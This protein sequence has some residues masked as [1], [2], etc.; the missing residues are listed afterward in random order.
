MGKRLPPEI[1]HHIVYWADGSVRKKMLF[2]KAFN[3]SVLAFQYAEASLHILESDLSKLFDMGHFLRTSLSPIQV[4]HLVRA[5][6]YCHRFQ[7]EKQLHDKTGFLVPRS[8][9]SYNVEGRSIV[10][11]VYVSRDDSHD[12]FVTK[13]RIYRD[14]FVSV[15]IPLCLTGAQFGLGLYQT[16]WTKKAITDSKLSF[17]ANLFFTIGAVASLALK[18]GGLWRARGPLAPA[19]LSFVIGFVP[20]SLLFYFCSKS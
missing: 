17:G 16:T 3:H 8:K 15:L 2:C 1:L 5:N 7:R 19:L 6:I 12:L 14:Y 13:A 20:V 18:I 11:A 9:Y 10:V 4:Q